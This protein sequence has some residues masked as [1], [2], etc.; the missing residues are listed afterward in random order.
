MSAG[1][2]YSIQVATGN[3]NAALDS[4]IGLLKQSAV[5]TGVVNTAMQGFGKSAVSS[6][7]GVEAAVNNLGGDFKTFGTNTT[8]AIGG[9]ETAVT[10]LGNDLKTHLQAQTDALIAGFDKATTKTR[11]F[12]SELDKLGSRAFALN[13]IKQAVDGIGN[14]INAAVQP[15]IDFNSQMA[16]T[17]AITGASDANMQKIGTSARQLAKDFGVTA[18]GGVDAYKLILSQLGPEIANVPEALAE[19]GKTST[20]LSKQMGGDVAA[21][22]GVLTTAMNQ[23]GV[24]LADPMKASQTMSVMMNIMAAAAKEGSAELPSI[25]TALEQAGAM[26]KVANVSFAETNASIQIL[27]KAGKKGAEGG[28]ALRNAFS[29]LGEGKFLSPVTLNML[30]AAGVSVKTLGDETLPFSARLNALKPIVGDVAAMT[31]LFGR[32]NVSAGVALVENSGA[33]AELT[34]KITGTNT[35][36]DMATTIMGSYEEQQKRTKARID[37][38][39]ISLFGVTQGFLPYIQFGMGALQVTANLAQSASLFSAIA[40]LRMWPAIGAAVVQLGSWIATTTAATLAQLGLNAAM[41]AN[42][43]GMLVLGITLAVAAVAALIH[44]WDDIWSAIKRFAVWMAEHNPFKWLIDI[45][46]K[47]FPGFKKAMGALWDWIVGKFEAL[48]GWFK[49]AWGWIKGLFGGGKDEAATASKAAVDEYA[50][51]IKTANIPGITTAGAAPGAGPLGG[52]DPHN[53]RGAGTSS[54]M[55]SNVSSG[56]NR[57]TTINLTIH[58]LQDQIVVHTT[59]LAM[60]AKEAANEIVEEILMALN[61]VNQ[62]GVASNG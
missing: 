12:E 38:V 21:S 33:I 43:I 37:D 11:S 54:E 27:D 61:S 22:T 30:K 9:V 1:V 53:R 29:I 23:Y 5:Q 58:K 45:V 15:G 35:A 26:A 6:I 24:S 34:G 49:K 25:K 46:D 52:F 44:W 3:S 41:D 20:I 2:Q 56:G 31:N 14:T 18:A 62:K 59:N 47:I 28:V 60:G 7:G 4:I 10:N 57:P 17:Q 16:E 42:P 8:A 32:E 13:N 19:M 40:S 50:K 48:V 36:V 51:Q 39:G 55:A